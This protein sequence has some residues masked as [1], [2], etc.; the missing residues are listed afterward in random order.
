MDITMPIMDG[1][2]CTKNIK[3]IK[4]NIKIV[5]LSA[6]GDEEIINEAKA[7]GVSIFLKKPFDDYK[8]ISALSSII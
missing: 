5:M 2:E 1:L 8:V 4:P 3:Q 7:A 6:M